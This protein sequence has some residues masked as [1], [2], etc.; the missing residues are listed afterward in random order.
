[1]SDATETGQPALHSQINRKNLYW[2]YG[3]GVNFRAAI[4]VYPSVRLGNGKLDEE[5]LCRQSRN[6]STIPLECS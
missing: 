2:P 4:H 5:T 6:L 3:K 1:M